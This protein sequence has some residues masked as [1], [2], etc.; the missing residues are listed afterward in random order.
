M[1]VMLLFVTMLFFSFLFHFSPPQIINKYDNQWNDNVKD[2]IGQ[3]IK[4]SQ[5]LIIFWNAGG[6]LTHHES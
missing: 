3:R 2:D 5:R 1:S 6:S 4:K